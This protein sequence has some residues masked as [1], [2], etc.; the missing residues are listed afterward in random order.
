MVKIT[1]DLW[2]WHHNVSEC[3]Y[4]IQLTRKYRR[5]VFRKEIEQE[6]LEI[7]TGKVIES[8]IK[9]QGREEDIKQWKLF[10]L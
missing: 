3:Y 1:E 7:M 10:E 2:Y 5:S 4:H 8:Y 6:M 9:K